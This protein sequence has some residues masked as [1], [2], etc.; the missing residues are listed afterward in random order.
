MTVD[1][2]RSRERARQLATRAVEL[3]SAEQT[4]VLA[5]VSDSA[6]TR[7]ADNRIHQNVA[8]RD[9]EISVRAVTGTRTGVASTNRT[10]DASLQACCDAALRAARSAPED[11]GFPGLPEPSPI[12]EVD[13]VAEGTVR[14]NAQARATAVRS[15]VDQSA[16]RNLLCAGGVKSTIQAIALANSRGIDV[17][18]ATSGI[19]ATVLSMGTTG[20]SG[21]ASFVSK[22]AEKLAAA[23]LGDEA[24]TLAERSE[25]PGELEPGSYTVVLAPEAVSDLMEFLG[26]LGMGA[27]SVEEGRSFM[28]NRFGESV[29]HESITIVDDALADHAFG[30]TFDYEGVPKQRV[31]LVEAGVAKDVVTDSYWAARME[32]ANTGHALPA[33]NSYGPLPLNVELA[34]GDATIDELLASV[35]RGVYV[36]RFHYVNVEDPIPVTLTGMTRDGTFLIEK[37]RLTQ[38]LKNLR[39]TQSVVEAFGDVRG[40]TRER[41]W[42]GSETN[43]VLVPGLLLGSFAFTGQTS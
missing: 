21:W 16:S 33:P 37:G 27:R 9:A 10:D 32:R 28:A 30:L 19:R 15:I 31:S 34:A 23:A 12:A 36:T 29:M 24:A 8:E 4:E 22:D 17:A 5:S 40:V 6:L 43:P 2:K 7:F 18:Q 35:D 39:F 38:P 20:G 42:V 11:P 1:P 41:M 13:R 14:F 25:N 26:W 3:S